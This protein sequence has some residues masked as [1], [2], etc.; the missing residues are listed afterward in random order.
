MH[1]DPQAPLAR[2]VVHWKHLALA[3]LAAAAILAFYRHDYW[4]PFDDTTQ[5]S[6]ASFHAYGF[7]A[8][9]T[10]NLW[11]NPV[12][13]RHVDITHSL[14]RPYTHWPNGFFLLFR[15]VLGIFGWT[16]AVGRWFAILCALLGFTLVVVSLN[17]AHSLHY[18][19]LPLILLSGAGRD[20]IP[21]VFL[22]SALYLFIGVLLFL[23]VSFSG[24]R[25]G[26]WVFRVAIILGLFF[27]HLVLPYAAA[28]AVLRWAE[29]RSARNLA[30]DL[31][32]IAA[33]GLGILAALA[34]GASTTR[35]GIAEVAAAFSF[36]ARYLFL[37]LLRTLSSDLR[38]LLQLSW[39]S[40]ALVAGAWW[41]LLRARRWRVVSLLPS[42]LVF[43]LILREYVGSHHFARIPLIFFCLVTLTAGADLAFQQLS[44]SRN[45]PASRMTAAKVLSLG[46][47]A[48]LIS[49]SPRRY[50]TDP[51]VKSSRD[52]LMR[53]VSDPAHRAAL[54]R[55]NAFQFHVHHHHYPP[56]DRMG[57]FFF[58][59]L[60]VERLRRGDPVR[61]CQVDLVNDSVR[62]PF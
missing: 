59:R 27:N 3:L 62:G 14:I 49:L 33:G 24:T 39:L 57:Q 2:L 10:T 36:R 37:A 46:V 42:F 34:A 44:A 61:T 21:F 60:A 41:F 28:I 35:A 4:R 17:S 51:L 43:A 20:S 53:L 26:N 55:C 18:A 32:V 56:D 52:S 5:E 12:V 58:A 8:A 16:E 30:L 38:D 15:G 54:S 11:P 29:T 47:L 6:V 19:A 45:W 22:D 50:H 9:S 13:A 7:A 31:A 23:H 40:V 1:P 48:A 25:H